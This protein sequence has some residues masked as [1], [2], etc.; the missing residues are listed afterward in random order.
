MAALVLTVAAGGTACDGQPAGPG[1]WSQLPQPTADPSAF[2]PVVS[3]SLVLD[4]GGRGPAAVDLPAHAQRFAHLVFRLHCLSAGPITVIDHARREVFGTGCSPTAADL[5]G[6]YD[7]VDVT[8]PTAA[9]ARFT[10][11]ADSHALWRLDI[12]TYG[13]T[14][15]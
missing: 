12:T 15:D 6:D 4:I 3:G 8:A 7:S 14:T 11:H 2:P 1:S 13:D 9:G 5:A 10:V